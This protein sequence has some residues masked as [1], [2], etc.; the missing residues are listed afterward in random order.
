M[1]WAA[2][3]KVKLSGEEVD[4]CLLRVLPLRLADDGQG[5][6]ESASTPPTAFALPRGGVVPEA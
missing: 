1:G 6:A 3:F 4:L 5:D 2:P